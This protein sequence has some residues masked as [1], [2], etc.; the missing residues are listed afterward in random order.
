MENKERVRL[1]QNYLNSL[2][3]NSKTDDE[4][5]SFKFKIKNLKLKEMIY[6]G[7]RKKTLVYDTIV[8]DIEP[9]SIKEFFLSKKIQ[10]L[11]KT[12]FYRTINRKSSQTLETYLRAF[13]L[14]GVE[15]VY[16][17]DILLDLKD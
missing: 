10:D 7:Q 17:S 4:L 11:T 6:V 9:D 12:P 5:I 3:F 8:I 13:S 2:I 1:M 14:D 15:R 16:M